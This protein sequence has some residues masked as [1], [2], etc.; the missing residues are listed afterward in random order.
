MPIYGA[1]ALKSE[2]LINDAGSAAEGIVLTS[3]VEPSSLFVQNYKAEYGKLPDQ[4][5]AQGYDAMKAILTAISDGANSGEKLKDSLKG[6]DFEG[7][8]G[9]VKFS[10]TGS[11]IGGYS[12]YTVKNGEYV[13]R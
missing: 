1:E 6:I 12:A 9:H 3:L 5:A 10:L 2:T 7:Y 8:S 4:Y 11:V 13:K